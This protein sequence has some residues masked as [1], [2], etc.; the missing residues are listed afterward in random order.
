MRIVGAYSSYRICVISLLCL[1]YMIKGFQTFLNGYDFYMLKNYEPGP[2]VDQ[3]KVFNT[4][5]ILLA[6]LFAISIIWWIK[7]HD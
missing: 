6:R 7:K 4:I 1:D 3:N 5:I 2:I